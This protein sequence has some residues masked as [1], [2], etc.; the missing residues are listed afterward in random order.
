[1]W[2]V[3]VSMQ[4]LEDGDWYMHACMHGYTCGGP[5]IYQF[6]WCPTDHAKRLGWTHGSARLVCK[7]IK[8]KI[9]AVLLKWTLIKGWIWSLLLVFFFSFFCQWPRDMKWTC[10]SRDRSYMELPHKRVC[11]IWHFMSQAMLKGGSFSRLTTK[12][13]RCI[14]EDRINTMLHYKRYLINLVDHS[15]DSLI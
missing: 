3:E 14:K 10:Q 8:I 13:Q 5:H 11:P 12:R 1:M 4:L 9:C 7:K 2:W 6:T 15:H